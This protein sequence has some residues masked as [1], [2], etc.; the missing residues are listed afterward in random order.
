MTASLMHTT[1]PIPKGSFWKSFDANVCNMGIDPS[2]DRMANYDGIC[3]QMILISK[4][5]ILNNIKSI[6]FD[7]SAKTRAEKK[8]MAKH[9]LTMSLHNTKCCSATDLPHHSTITKQPD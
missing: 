7:L 8:I 4:I 2:K 1:V 3:E 5:P 9:L 6:D